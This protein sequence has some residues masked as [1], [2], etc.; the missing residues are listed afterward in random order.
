MTTRIVGYVRVSTTKQ[1]DEGVSV[2]AQEEK[3]RAYAELYDLDLIGITWD[4]GLSAKTLE[5][6]GLQEALEMLMNGEA[7]SLLVCK[8]DR[9]TRSVKDLGILIETY[10]G[11]GRNFGLVSVAEQFDTR[12]AAGRLVLNVMTSVAEFERHAIGERTSMAMRHMRENRQYT[13]GKVRF[14]YRL[15]SDG[16]SLVEMEDEQKVIDIARTL[17]G[18][19][20]SLRSISRELSGMGYLSRSGRPFS[21]SQIRSLVVA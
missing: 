13:G 5:R 8:L 14:G 20:L 10:F 4:R 12:T 18:N 16:K 6:P 21:A 19:G 17:H 9:L 7:D 15:G 3:I 1:V 11:P 2:D